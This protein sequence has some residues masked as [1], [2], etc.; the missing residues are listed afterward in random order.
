MD[1]WRDGGTERG[2]GEREGWRGEEMEVGRDGEGDGE[3]NGKGW[4]EMEV[5]MERDGKSK[6]VY[7]IRPATEKVSD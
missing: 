3:E 5:E 4:E 2:M 6:S 7:D 1:G